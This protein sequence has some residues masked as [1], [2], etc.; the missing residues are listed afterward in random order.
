[1]SK[2]KERINVYGEE[3]TVVSGNGIPCKVY[4]NI[5]EAYG[6]PSTRKV[7]IWEA[8]KNWF[9]EVLRD[10]N[11][12]EIYITSRNTNFF[13]VGGYI[14]TPINETWAFYITATRQEIWRVL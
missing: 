13:T 9:Y 7:A 1:M 6:R 8:W 10:N 14:E 2:R 12:G 3:F 11:D 4:D 5:Y